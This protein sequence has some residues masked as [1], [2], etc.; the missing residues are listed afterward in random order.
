MM[1]IDDW[2]RWRY[3][4][5]WKYL[6]V[7]FGFTTEYDKRTRGWVF[8][9]R[10]IPLFAFCFN[11]RFPSWNEYCVIE[12]SFWI[13]ILPGFTEPGGTI[14]LTYEKQWARTNMLDYLSPEEAAAHH[15]N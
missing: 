6:R 9:V 10:C 8:A 15:G 1:H 11:Y 2:R 7:C 13:S 12:T 4:R 14:R 5:N 3:F